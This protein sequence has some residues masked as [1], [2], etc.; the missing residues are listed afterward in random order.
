MLMSYFTIEL[1]VLLRKRLY[2]I[3]SICLP[4]FFY[5]LFTSIL[6]LPKS[7]RIIFYKEYMYSMVVF[8]CMN[9]CLISFPV[10]MIEERT[11]G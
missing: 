8:S 1:K 6:D 9:F 4:L 7:E 11:N 5:L 2:L 3:M 10:D